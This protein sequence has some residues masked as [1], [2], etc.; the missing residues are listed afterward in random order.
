[1][2]CPTCKKGNLRKKV[3]IEIDLDITNYNLSKRALRKRNVQITCVHWPHERHY[4]PK[5]LWSSERKVVFE[6]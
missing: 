4:C 6:D 5:C 3:L 1:M 2:K